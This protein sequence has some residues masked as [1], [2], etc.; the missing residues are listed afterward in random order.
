MPLIQSAVLFKISSSVVGRV[1][2]DEIYP[3]LMNYLE[4]L[5]QPLQMAVVLELQVDALA[6]KLCL[7]GRQSALVEELRGVEFDEK[8][9]Y[10]IRG[11]LQIFERVVGNLQI[12]ARECAP[13]NKRGVAIEKPAVQIDLLPKVLSWAMNYRRALNRALFYL[14]K[15]QRLLLC[16]RVPRLLRRRYRLLKEGAGCNNF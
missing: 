12:G 9:L 3:R 1:V 2:D 16:K 6:L 13:L 5:L 10:H 4:I 7:E 14:S 15:R 8:P 11:A